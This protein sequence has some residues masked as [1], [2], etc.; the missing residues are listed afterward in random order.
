MK[1]L[2]TR[3]YSKKQENAVAKAVNGKR[4]PNSGATAFIKGDVQTK[5]FLIECKTA[6]TEKQTVSIAKKWIIKNEEE[7]FAMGKSYSAVAF[8][9]GSGDQ[10]Y[11]INEKL[12]KKL[13][14]ILE[15]E[16]N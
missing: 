9:F 12:F 2:P 1:K 8:D 13:V 16:E 7:A 6:T 3:Y 5:Q 11:V 4:T 15:E 10:Y 14:N